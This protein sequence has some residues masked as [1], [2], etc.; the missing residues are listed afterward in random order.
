MQILTSILLI[1]TINFVVQYVKEKYGI[2]AR[3][4]LLFIS[5]VL[6]ALYY[7]LSETNPD[8]LA[9]AMAFGTQASFYAILVY[10]FLLKKILENP[11]NT[12]L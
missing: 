2:S 3:Y 5:V 12:L 7:V 1:P 9:N 11:D 6:G 4:T 10:E 8:L